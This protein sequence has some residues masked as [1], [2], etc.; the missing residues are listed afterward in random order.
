MVRRVLVERSI[1]G[2][3]RGYDEYYVHHEFFGGKVGEF[4]KVLVKYVED[5]GVVSKCVD[6]V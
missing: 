3:S 5:E 2:I 6:M 4:Q 1:G